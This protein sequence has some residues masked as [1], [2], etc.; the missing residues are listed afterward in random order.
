MIKKLYRP[1]FEIALQE[2][3]AGSVVI[4]AAGEVFR[5]TGGKCGFDLGGFDLGKIKL[6]DAAFNV[7]SD[8]VSYPVMLIELGSDGM[9]D[10]EP[11]S[12]LDYL[13][14]VWEEAAEPQDG[15]IPAGSVV[16]YRND[17]DRPDYQVWTAR[18]DRDVGPFL[19]L[20]IVSSPPKVGFY[21]QH[22]GYAYY[23]DG[24]VWRLGKGG[25]RGAFQDYVFS[26]YIGD[27]K[28]EK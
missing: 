27:V 12:V 13:T 18:T 3:P 1:E 9:I 7:L 22:D 10:K 14:K 25:P 28:E 17:Y 11:E 20:R 6:R 4:D 23:W 16:V 19:N 21:M 2:A 24:S 26:T 5:Y 8:V 15:F